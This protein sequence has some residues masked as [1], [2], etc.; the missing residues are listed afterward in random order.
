MKKLGNILAI[1]CLVSVSP[2][3]AA[4]PVK[5]NRS[6]WKLPLST[7]WHL[8]S[9]AKV[10]EDGSKLSLPR[11]SSSGW[12]STTIPSTVVSS[13]VK[14]NIYLDPFFGMNLRGISGTA[15]KPG[16]N[17][18]NFEMPDDSPFKVSWWY[19]TNFRLPATYAGMQIWLHLDGINYRANIWMNGK[20]IAG[21]EEVAG[22]WRV[23]E[24]NVTA[25]A[26]PGKTNGLAVEVF[27]PHADDLAITWVDWNPMPADKDMGLWRPVYLTA[28]GPVELCHPQ[29][30]TKVDRPA[31]DAAHLTVSA[32]LRN[33]TNTT[34]SGELKGRVGDIEFSEQVEIP[35]RE[36]QTI[37]FAP[38]QFP[39]LNV[40]NPKL[41]WPWQMGPQNLYR[42]E[43]RFES[44]DEV[45]DSTE[46]QFGIRDI[47][48]TLNEQGSRQYYVNG[49][50]ILIL[51]GGW[52]PD[53]MM[54]EMPEKTEA[55]IRYTRDM[56]LNTIR[57]E[58]KLETEQFFQL[59]DRYGILVLAGWCCCD[60]WEHWKSWKPEDYKVA[61]ESLRDQL[62]RLRNHA[63]LLGW[64][65]G[66]DN[67][68][69]PQVEQIYLRVFE[70]C[71]WPNPHQSSA[72]ARPTSVTGPTGLKMTGPY[73]WVP[74]NYWLLDT[75]NGGA[76]GFNTETS[77][78]PAVPPLA[79][80]KKML[81]ADHLW[82]IDDVWS[83]HA[84]GGLFSTINIFTKALNERYGQATSVDDFAEKSQLMT[85]EG[86]R[87]MFE[88][89]RRNQPVSTGVIQWM[90]NNAWPSLIWHLYD[91]YLRPAGGYFGAK[92]AC[93]P[94]HIQYSY[95]DRSVV[96]VN[97]LQ[98]GFKSLSATAEV[99]DFALNKK[100]ANTVTVDAGPDSVARV[101]TIPE[102]AD[103]SKT[104]FVRLALRDA[105]GALKSSNFYWLSTQRDELD[106][107]KT[108]WYYTP[109]TRYADFTMLKNLPAV[110]LQIKKTLRVSGPNQEMMV[111]LRN[112]SPNI[113]FFVHL[114]VNR[115]RGGEEILPVLWQDNY[116]ELM[117]G[118]QRQ[119]S[120]VFSYSRGDDSSRRATLAVDGWNV[121]K[122]NDVA[123]K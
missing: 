36:T 63:C 26:L 6:P 59:C 67:P 10:N 78:G 46:L 70:E 88:A 30:L 79:S 29:V 11:Y 93:E 105:A 77:P 56:H 34:V 32:E 20:K 35:A 117:P 90:L 51:G 44:K 18:S 65:Y 114:Q 87:A 73:D 89:Y 16:Q 99:Y 37:T 96:V 74:P 42:L 109:V 107:G 80:L 62:Y 39:Q 72:T 41:W 123:D 101:L 50:K 104:Y 61:E 86:E 122:V 112:P 69:P 15:Y 84:G 22:A 2:G 27:A 38:E 19:Q 52:A 14:N 7:G 98:E 12:Y 94:L 91:Y 48:S 92:I 103:L 66:S 49:K 43:L 113:A 53:M 57:L 60:H 64:L 33:P 83:Y 25:Q 95:D 115:G 31:L 119:V 71:H 8:Q 100:F 120:A 55:E 23:F 9:S 54:R 5:S 21:A 40:R 75:K 102:I 24:F 3:Y 110:H 82:P 111:T 1:L 116:F 28:T 118:E 47:T 76:Y 13:L 97:S 121:A 68:P 108:T 85:Y 58:G 106:W 17:F 4:T 81:P 45:S